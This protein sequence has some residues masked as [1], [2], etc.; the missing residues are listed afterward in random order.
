MFVCVRRVH[1]RCAR[2]KM[3]VNPN[4]QDWHPI[5]LG[6]G[7]T[8]PRRVA[9]TVP[10]VDEATARARKAE[11]ETEDFTLKTVARSAAAE[12]RELRTR[13]GWTQK[14]LAAAIN[15]RPDVVRGWEAGTAV[16]NGALLVKMRRALK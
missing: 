11:A 13:K 10:V 8:V 16:P 3:Q 7:K 2:T 1:A 12:I 14:Q 5:T 6:Q 4:V 9:H 15:E